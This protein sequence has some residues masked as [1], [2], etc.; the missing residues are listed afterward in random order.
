MSRTAVVVGSGPNGLAAAIVLARAGWE[1]TVVE[2]GATPGGGCRSAELTLPGF[3]HD[4]CSAVHPLGAASPFFAELPLAEQGLEYLQPELPLAHP[5][6]DGTAAALHRSP[7][8]TAATLDPADRS[9]YRRLVEPFADDWERLAPEL[10]APLHLPRA[11]LAMARFG[12]SALR[13]AEGLARSRFEGP[14]ARALLAGLAGHSVLPLDRAASAAIGLVLAAAG[15]AVGWPLPRGGAQAV[16]DAL[17]AV[18]E[19]LGGGVE[20]GRPVRTLDDLPV[21]FDALDA[22]LFDLAPRQVAQ[23]ADSELPASY[24]RRLAAF[25]HG[26]G[27]FKIDWALS[28]QIPWAA[29]ECARAG[30][31]H[32]GGTLE[33]IAE[34]EARVWGGEHPERPFVLLVQPGVV[35]PGRAPAGHAVGW[36][37][38]HVPNGSGTDCTEAIEAQVERFAPGFRD[39]ILARKTL[40]AVEI[41]TYN[42]SYVGGDIAGGSTELGQLFARPV[43]RPT[44][45]ATPNRKLWICS[46]STP[47]GGG[48]HGMCGYHAATALLRSQRG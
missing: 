33:E 25:R 4:V 3:R 6:D 48:V 46:A 24:R 11:P 15:H 44:P 17:V 26:P 45:Y 21:P 20:T 22:V 42:P 35:D 29:E 10:L 27:V 1:V 7:A 31:V 14:R 23:I 19:E 32:L 38:C 47:P 37:Y 34:G 18:L 12:R 5:L 2:G 28:G 43:A 39:L 41:E 30:T 16:T 13:S 9:A 36:A 40:T 8:A